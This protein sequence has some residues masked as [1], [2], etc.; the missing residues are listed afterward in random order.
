MKTFGLPKK[1]SISLCTILLASSPLLANSKQTNK[2]KT[3]ELDSVTI[4]GSETSNYLTKEKPSLNRTNIDIENSA[5]SIQVFN[6]DLIQD[7]QI[8]NIEDII[9]MSSNTTY[10]GDS[11]GRTTQIGMRGFS[12]VPIL[13][14]SLK[15]TNKIA[16]PE[17]Y[18][19]ERVE[20]LKGPDSLQYGESSPGG[21]VNLV[22][23]KPQKEAS[24]EI[25][26]ELT[27]NNSY[28]PK[29][30]VTGSIN[31]DGSLRYRLVSTL[32]YDEGYT[33]SNTDTNRV[34]LA[35]SIAYDFDENNTLTILAEY[36]DETSASAFGTYVNSKGKLVAPLKNTISN[37]DEE[38]K[39]TQKI[40]GF[41]FDSSFDTWNSNL[42]YRYIDY[43]GDNG[44][45]HMPLSFNEATNTVNRAYAYQKQEF[46]EHV[47]Q[48]TLNKQVNILD[49]KNNISAG[50]DY[51]KAYS[52]LDMFFDPFA[53][54]NIDISHPD[55]ESLTDL[56]DHS[57]AMNMSKDKTYVKSWGTFLQ[58]SI[59]LTDDLIFSAGVRY[60]ESKPQNGQRSEATTPSFGLVYKITPQTSIYTNYSESFNPNSANDIK[61]N[62]LDP[63]EGKGYEIGVKQKLFN[64]NLHLTAA[65]FKIEKKNIA[66]SDP[67]DPTNQ[68]S[69]AS[70]VQKSKGFEFDLSGQI[71]SN[72]SIVASY[73]YTDTKNK[74]NNDNELRNIPKHTANI[75]TT[76]NLTS[77]N[78]PNMYIGGGAR[79]LGS[80]YADD[81][82]KIKFDSEIIYNATLG[83]KKGNYRVNFSVQNLTDEKYVDGALSS[84]AR[85]TRVY[86]GTARAVMASISYRF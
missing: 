16:H 20:V 60:S 68:A 65:M 52:K 72:W 36:T 84:N 14:D 49:F 70:G 62:I 15:I 44:N 83:Y 12:S 25:S 28:T 53:A 71:T 13:F 9:Q 17:I 23:K 8:Q 43:V 18:N 11:H 80:R 32:K 3:K 75:F 76:Y 2:E 45:V 67:N 46:Q 27:D 10:Q 82:N 6:Q 31:E 50:I 24:S 19:L 63:E 41:D 21:L 69:I 54:Y 26:L 81:A 35:P 34:F 37:P 56:S 1:L 4:I 86:A 64:D 77:L 73:G 59:N 30:D 78:L 57:G 58:D 48:Y 74:D 79:Y 51:N 5:K 66:L 85:G 47:L 29:L 39:K 40:V 42:R 38:F 7:A 22:S 33:N 61:G 55:Y